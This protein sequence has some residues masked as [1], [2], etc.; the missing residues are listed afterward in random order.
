MRKV[1]KLTKL[2]FGQWQGGK[3]CIPIDEIVGVEG[4][5]SVNGYVEGGAQ[6]IMRTYR[7]PVKEKQV[8]I[9]EALEW[10]VVKVKKGDRDARESSHSNK[11]K[12]SKSGSK[13]SGSKVG[14]GLFE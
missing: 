7:I 10:E 6:I 14:R 13:V 4:P 12:S 11:S 3:V 9:I 2:S 1:I 5:T 8:D